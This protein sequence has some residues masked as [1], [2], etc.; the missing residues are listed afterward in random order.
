VSLVD[1]MASEVRGKEKEKATAG[2]STGSAGSGTKNG[3]RN[4][5]THLSTSRRHR[6][7]AGQGTNTSNRNGNGRNSKGHRAQVNSNRNGRGNS[8]SSRRSATNGANSSNNRSNS[9]SNSRHGNT[10]NN[11]SR[12]QR[13][14]TSNTVTGKD[15]SVAHRKAFAADDTTEHSLVQVRGQK[16]QQEQQDFR[17]SNSNRRGNNQSGK[18]VAQKGHGEYQSQRGGGNGRR[19]NKSR[20]RYGNH[21]NGGRQ[22]G[23]YRNRNNRGTNNNNNSNNKNN[24]NNN[25]NNN[26][27]INHNVNNN[28]ESH[29]N[30]MQ[31][32]SQMHPQQMQAMPSHFQGYPMIYGMAAP[33]AYYPMNGDPNQ[34]YQHPDFYQMNAQHAGPMGPYGAPPTMVGYQYPAMPPRYVNNG[35][36]EAQQQIPPQYMEHSQRNPDGGGGLA[37][38]RGWVDG[39]PP[40][41]AGPTVHHDTDVENVLSAMSSAGPD[42]KIF[43]IDV[44]CVATGVRAQDRAAAR[45]VLV[46]MEDE[47][48]F[49]EFIKPQD[50]VFS[51]ITELTG[52]KPSDLESAAPLSVVLEK[53]NEILGPD[54]YLVG[55]SVHHDI[56]WM[57]LQKGRDYRESLD[58]SHLFRTPKARLDGSFFMLY[59]SL[60]HECKYLLH[61]DIQQGIHDPTEDARGA[62]NLFKKFRKTTPQYILTCQAVLLR[63]PR[64]ASFAQTHKIVDGVSMSRDNDEKAIARHKEAQQK[65]VTGQSKKS[66]PDSDVGA[67]ATSSNGKEEDNEAPRNDE[68]VVIES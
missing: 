32:M 60:K 41:R 1:V 38:G 20:N 61:E 27:R 25:N 7:G 36:Y 31:T 65:E 2:V 42:E 14:L 29:V 23:H 34:M 55:Q 46:S 64:T 11:G 52:I 48:V 9:S 22:Q 67:T 6:G 58:V 17:Q 51:C 63:S 24:N 16:P 30:T 54:A 50:K 35:P 4:Q 3:S 43:G 39:P 28:Y 12:V 26:N 45:I 44:E 21:H 59:H 53:L 19:K 47:V 37:Q 62:L 13:A 40:H 56:D 33:T 5:Q 18:T 10:Y 57:T 68:K 66:L 8:L 49:D 15:N